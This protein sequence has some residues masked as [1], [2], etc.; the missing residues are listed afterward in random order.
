MHTTEATEL[1]AVVTHFLFDAETV[2]NTHTV[3][4][5]TLQHELLQLYMGSNNGTF[6]E[7]GVYSCLPKK[8]GPISVRALFVICNFRGR[9]EVKYSILYVGAI[10]LMW[11]S[12]GG[13]GR[14]H[15]VM[16]NCV[17]SK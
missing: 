2:A 7:T 15:S 8:R 10:I 6:S 5:V 17:T 16:V 3:K 9:A 14:A 1:S 4:I 12:A 13:K 11:N